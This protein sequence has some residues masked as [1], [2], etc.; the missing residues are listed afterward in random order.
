[1]ARRCEC[2]FLEDNVHPLS[3]LFLSAINRKR[4]RR[5]LTDSWTKEIVTFDYDS[6]CLGIVPLL[7]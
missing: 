2:V 3:I 6:V 4:R 7:L 1:M 5:F